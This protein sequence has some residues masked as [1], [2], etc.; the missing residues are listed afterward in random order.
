MYGVW[1][2]TIASRVSV[3][4]MSRCRKVRLIR[5]T[6]ML[7]GCFKVKEFFMELIKRDWIITSLNN[8]G[9]LFV[10]ITKSLKNSF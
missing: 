3:G 2:L 7:E 5:V 8:P 4:E 6:D 10:V 1:C 9:Q